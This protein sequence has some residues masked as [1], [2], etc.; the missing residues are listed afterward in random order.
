MADI[1][2]NALA[3]TATTPASD[4]YLA[5]DGTA[6]GT[7]KIL[8]TNIAN[9]VTD[10]IL[11]SSGPS[12]KS[13]LSARAPRQGLVFDSSHGT[14][15]ATVTN[16]PAFGQGI[17]GSTSGDFTFAAWVREESTFAGTPI[18]VIGNA[19][20]GFYCEFNSSG[21]PYV[22]VQGGSILL[23]TATCVVG[24][25]YLL[26]YTRTGNTGT[27]YIDGVATNSLTDGINYTHPFANVSF[28]SPYGL[29]GFCY[30]LAYNRC[31][32]ATEVKALYEAG[33]PAGADYNSA[34]NTGIITGQNNTFNGGIGNWTSG[35]TGTVAAG[36]NVMNCT[37]GST[38]DNLAGYLT[39]VNAGYNPKGYYVR[40]TADITNNSGTV[41]IGVGRAVLTQIGSLA[42]NGTF[43]ATAFLPATTDADSF[44]ICGA[45]SSQTFTVDNFQ[46]FRLGLLLAPDAAQAGGGLVWYDTSGNA[47][48]ISWTSGV[49]WNVPSSRVLGGNWTT[50][51]NLNVAGVGTFNKSLDNITT[52]AD[53]AIRIKTSAEDGGLYLGANS[54]ISAIQAID[55]GTT[56]DRKLAI[57]PNGGNVLV[58]GTADGGQKLQ[59]SGTAYVSGGFFAGG[60]VNVASG[61]SLTA[62]D[63]GNTYRAILRG[64]AD[65]TVEIGWATATPTNGHLIFKAGGS[66]QGRIN[67]SGGWI[68]GLTGSAPFLGTNST[69]TF[70]LTSNTSLTIK[71]RGTD[72]TTRSANLTLS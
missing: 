67:P 37:A 2:I 24:K 21:V 30:P 22:G 60:S 9:N 47:A 36:T 35:G 70:E 68:L 10:V 13:S 41:R 45:T 55:P 8:A 31:L 65:D 6:Q 25:T 32:S 15:Y 63:S 26:T 33:A 46:V 56:F 54:T 64:I 19:A 66:E 28:A 34:S 11:G 4:D 53:Y 57:Q 3:T 51:G 18:V 48:N 16:I 72:G 49:S 61:Y 42:G 44:W 71:V 43:D 52:E 62:Q 29:H 1:R 39:F 69:M 12:V 17:A 59:V 40:V 14:T 58:G 5:L 38:A 7:R 27:W 23:S 50:S 20:G